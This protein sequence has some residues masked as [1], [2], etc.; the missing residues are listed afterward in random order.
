MP[1]EL[2]ECPHDNET[3]CEMDTPCTECEKFD[4]SG[5]FKDSG[6]DK[7]FNAETT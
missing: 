5:L 7:V 2:Y 4:Q 3:V 1:Q 6:L